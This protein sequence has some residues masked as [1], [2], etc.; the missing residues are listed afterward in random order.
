MK[1]K[2]IEILSSPDSMGRYV[3]FVDWDN[4]TKAYCG[5][6]GKDPA[7]QCEHVGTPEYGKCAQ[8]FFAPLPAA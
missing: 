4:P 5:V 8:I 7:R 2:R 3:Y 6:C 1:N